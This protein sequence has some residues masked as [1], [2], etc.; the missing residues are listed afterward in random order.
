[1][2]DRFR[3]KKIKFAIPLTS[4][5]GIFA[6]YLV[7]VGGEFILFNLH[8]CCLEWFGWVEDLLFRIQTFWRENYILLN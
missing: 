2:D 7:V 8:F 4:E 3:K 5:S 1:M 6:C